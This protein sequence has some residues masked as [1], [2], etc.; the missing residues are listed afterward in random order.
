MSENQKLNFWIALNVTKTL[1]RIS[2]E[3][4]A[5]VEACCREA[6]EEPHPNLQ[7]TQPWRFV[8]CCPNYTTNADSAMQV[9]EICRKHTEKLAHD[10]QCFSVR[11]DIDAGGCYISLLDQK[12]MTNK[13]GTYFEDVTELPLAICQ[14]AKKLFEVT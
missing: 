1:R 11:I 9:L 3:E 7:L 13:H 5:E 12:Y 6:N 14:F 10:E 2:D 4:F 8:G